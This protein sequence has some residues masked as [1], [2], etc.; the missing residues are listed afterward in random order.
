MF[1]N[2]TALTSL[3]IVW[4]R[5]HNRVASKLSEINPHWDDER[6]YQE[7]KRIVVGMLQHITMNEF[8]PLLL[9]KLWMLR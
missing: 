6:L 2:V 4:L 9:G 8:L 3:H 7:T 5:E 1:K